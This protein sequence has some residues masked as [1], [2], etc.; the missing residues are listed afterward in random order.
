VKTKKWMASLAVGTALLG[1]TLSVNAQ[2]VQ[3]S[4]ATPIAPGCGP[5]EGWTK[6]GARYQCETPQPSCAYGFASGPVWTGS[7]WSFSC[8]AP[9]PPSQPTSPPGGG[10][11]TPTPEDTCAARAASVGISVG[12]LTHVYGPQGNGWSNYVY[13]NATGPETYDINGGNAGYA[14]VVSCNL[15]PD[16]VTWAPGNTNPFEYFPGGDAF[17]NPPPASSGGG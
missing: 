13:D 16:G 11:K 1:P 5:G 14:W 6:N 15:Y 10:T 17:V 7:S 2:Y 8:N 3:N 12:P 4:I 9:P